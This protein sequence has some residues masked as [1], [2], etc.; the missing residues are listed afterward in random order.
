ME[1]YDIL[2]F[3]G[4]LHGLANQ[5]VLRWIKELQQQLGDN[6]STEAVEA[7]IWATLKSGKVLL[8]PVHLHHDIHFS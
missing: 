7:Y 3:A 5:E 6:P 4:P 1:S 2:R 8:L